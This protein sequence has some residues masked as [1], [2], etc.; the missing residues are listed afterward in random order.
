[1][2][3]HGPAARRSRDE[4]KPGMTSV[5]LSILALIAA[6]LSG[7]GDNK[8]APGDPVTADE[9]RRELTGLPL[10]GTPKTGDFS[11][12]Q[13]CSVHLADGTFILAGS[14]T[15]LR[16]LWEFDGSRVCR[17]DPA[18]SR[19]RRRCVDYQRLANNRFRNSDGVEFCIGPCP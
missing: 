2:T 16:G 15:V 6:L 1:L 13:M 8:S 4:A 9:F 18:E 7:C 12:K 10:C 11:G 5:R 3:F 17:R 19:D 14:G